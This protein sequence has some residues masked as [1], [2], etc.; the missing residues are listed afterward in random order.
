[1]TSVFL[2]T[3][4]DFDNMENDFFRAVVTKKIGFAD[5]K[6]EADAW[7]SRQKKF[8]YVGWDRSEYPHYT[9]EE[10]SRLG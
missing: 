7:V 1:M 6:D 3:K 8:E 9:V 5:S 4:V 10:I 2:V